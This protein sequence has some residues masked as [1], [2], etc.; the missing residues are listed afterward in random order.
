MEFQFNGGMN[1][2]DTFLLGQ[3]PVFHRRGSTIEDTRSRYLAVAFLRHEKTFTPKVDHLVA[4]VT[5]LSLEI[6]QMRAHTLW[7]VL[8]TFAVVGAFPNAN[9]LI[10]CVHVC[11]FS[12]I[13]P[14]ASVQQI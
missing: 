13:D 14:T 12:T 8:V 7:T 11:Q 4:M 10:S 5:N 1:A 2:S 3:P 6:T 9:L